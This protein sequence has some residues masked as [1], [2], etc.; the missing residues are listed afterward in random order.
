MFGGFSSSFKLGRRGPTSPYS[1]ILPD[2]TGTTEVT[3]ADDTY[4]D[5]YSSQTSTTTDILGSNQ[6]R[7]LQLCFAHQ[8]LTIPFDATNRLAVGTY[9]TQVSS[10]KRTFAAIGIADNIQRFPATTTFITN[11]ATS[12]KTSSQGAFVEYPVGSLVSIPA[13]RWFL[14]GHSIIPF[15]AARSMA[16]PRTATIGGTYYF[17][18]FPI[19]YLYSSQSEGRTPAELGGFAR[20]FLKYTGYTNVMSVKFK[21]A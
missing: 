12:G 8:A 1:E 6:N 15:R 14:I 21:L 17:T 4:F 11:D 7:T 20:P 3:W 18:V 16:A 5:F 13:N 10:P 2:T 19:I 9:S